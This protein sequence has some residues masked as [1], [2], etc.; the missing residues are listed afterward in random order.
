MNHLPFSEVSVGRPSPLGATLDANGVNFALFSAHAD[1]V[2]LCLFDS[3]GKHELQRVEL[4]AR[5]NDIWHGYLPQA[6]ADLL[7]GYRVHGRYRPQE[8]HRFNAHKLLVDPYAKSLAGEIEWSD[9]HFGYRIGQSTAD[10]SLDQRDNAR[11]M[12]KCRVIDPA[13]N[14]E[15]DRPPRTPWKDTV[16]YELHVK[17]FTIAHPSV[18]PELRGTYAGLA[19][20]PV[21]EHLKRIGVTAV[22]L[23]PIHAFAQDRHLVE[24]GLRNFWGYNSLAF[25]TPQPSYCATGSISEFKTMVKALH[26]AGIEV[27]LDVVYNHTAEGNQMGPTLSMRG[28]DNASYYRLVTGN[29]RYY[30]DYTGCG[31]TL[32]T[33]NSHVLELIRDSLRYWVEDMHVDGFRFDLG[34]AL[35][36]DMTGVE[37]RGAFLQEIARDP[38]LSQVKMIAEPWDLGPGGYQLGGF[39]AG[40]GEWN[41][42]YRDTMR[43]FGKGDAQTLGEFATRFTGSSDL[44]ERSGRAPQSSIN[45]L[46]AHDGFTLHDLVSYN[47]K[48]N[49][50]NLESNRDGTDNNQSWNCGIEGQTEDETISTLR[51]RQKRNLLTMLFLSQGVPMLLAGDEMGRSQGGNNNA[52][53]Q[54]NA[55]SWVNWSLKAE[56]RQL[57]AFVR[58]LIRLRR[59]RPILRRTAFFHGRAVGASG[60]KDITWLRP[61]GQEMQDQDWHQSKT[62]CLGIF[63]SPDSRTGEPYANPPDPTP[64]FWSRLWSLMRG[65]FKPDAGAASHPIAR[66]SLLSRL[67][68]RPVNQGSASIEGSFL[69]LVNV[70][71]ETIEFVLPR[72]DDRLIWSTVIDTYFEDGWKSDGRIQHSPTYASNGRSLV[73][74]QAKTKRRTL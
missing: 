17:G 44:F 63:F 22:E 15:D 24:R 13:Y 37:M 68:R 72:L 11:L 48:R 27:I 59:A 2:E 67:W 53:C 62:P 26:A 47:H 70:H 3:S 64:N 23:L 56:D 5:T 30:M 61:D 31:N 41:D 29:A 45:F 73:V 51:R 57:R 65:M 32:D 50:A 20:A 55:V 43:S 21:I 12:P 28:I 38:V 58:R 36:R 14:W 71:H 34:V 18:P 49:E 54:D 39:P 35:T 10:L 66:G 52:Y 6:R 19:S 4:R 9:A 16:I 25:L 7:Y 60:T 42:R 69:I 33:S 74:L 40:W 1:R 46:T 8:G